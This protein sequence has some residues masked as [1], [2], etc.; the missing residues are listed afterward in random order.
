MQRVAT[1]TLTHPVFPRTT[2]TRAVFRIPNHAALSPNGVSLELSSLSAGIGRTLYPITLALRLTAGRARLGEQQEQHAIEYDPLDRDVTDVSTLGDIQNHILEVY[3]A[4]DV[5]GM[6]LRAPV[7]NVTQT[8]PTRTRPIPKSRWSWRGPRDSG[9]WSNSKLIL[10]AL[11]YDDDKILPLGEF[12]PQMAHV[13]GWVVESLHPKFRTLPSERARRK[14]YAVAHNMNFADTLDELSDYGR[15]KAIGDDAAQLLPG[16]EYR[17][18]VVRRALEVVEELQL[19]LFEMTDATAVAQRLNQ[20]MQERMREH[21][22]PSA[23]RVLC[24]QTQIGLVVDQTRLMVQVGFRGNVATLE[25][26]GWKTFQTY[27]DTEQPEKLA[28]YGDPTEFKPGV[29]TPITRYPL[30][31]TSPNIRPNTFIAGRG[32]DSVIGYLRAGNQVDRT[33]FKGLVFLNT[34][35]SDQ[36]LTLQFRDKYGNRVVFSDQLNIFTTW[37]V[38]SK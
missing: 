4:L 1:V 6:F 23:G 5:R 37:N 17:I 14:T 7:A 26:L 29:L 3:R 12:E 38:Y 27:V 2:E 24:A 9:L 20:T 28:R 36:H 33:M 31:I 30:T 34:A 10:L 8:L 19:Q 15:V 35:D 21:N 13:G 18:G 25:M 16:E 32:E 11:G 22:I